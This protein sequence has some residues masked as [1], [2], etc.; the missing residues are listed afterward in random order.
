[1]QIEFEGQLYEFPDDA[2]DVEIAEALESVTPQQP[3]PS[4]GMADRAGAPTSDLAPGFSVVHTPATNAPLIVTM[5][6]GTD[7]SFPADMPHDEIRR[8]IAGKFPN[9][10]P[11]G[12]KIVSQPDSPPSTAYDVAAAIPSGLAR[13]AVETVMAPVTAGRLA[14]DGMGW[15]YDKGEAG[16]RALIGA[17]PAAANSEIEAWRDYNPIRDLIFGAQDSV[18]GVMDD[19]L[20]EAKTLAGKFAQTGAEFAAPGALPGKAARLAPT[21]AGKAGNYARDFFGNVAAPAVLSEGAGQLTEG[22]SWEG[23]ARALAAVSGNAAVAA[24]R[25]FNAPDSVVRRAT[26]D[27]SDTDWQRAIGLQDNTTGIRLTGPEAIA[28][29][30]GG[31]SALPDVQRVIEGSVGGRAIT[32]PFFAQRPIQV[33]SAVAEVLDLIAPQAANPFT[34]GSRAAAAADNAITDVRGRINDSTRPLYQAAEPQRLPSPE[35]STVSSNP[36]FAAAVQRLRADRELGPRYAS[37]PDDSVGVIDAVAKDLFERGEA[38]GNKANPTYG[39]YKGSLSTGAAADARNAASRS[40]PE[41]AQ[42]LAEQER[43]RE[44]ILGPLEAGPVGQVA[45]TSDTASA[46]N[47]ILPQNPMTGSGR[48]TAL[49]VRMLDDQDPSATRGLIRQNLTDR[50]QRAATETQEGSREFAGAKFR[51]DVAGNDARQEVLDAVFG[52]LPNGPTREAADLLDVLQATGRRKPIGSA[53]AF[54]NSLQEELSGA[55]SLPGL[56]KSVGLSLGTYV[57]KAGDAVQRATMGRNIDTLADMFVDPRSVERIR[58]A[59]TRRPTAAFDDAARRS[60][61]QLGVS[62]P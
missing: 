55:Q 48:E 59:T 60:A 35:F 20:Y 2:T 53:T 22:T 40:S 36:S 45:K 4:Y 17:E 42:A 10:I 25:S 39:P 41:Y 34:L 61:L 62:A 37:M 14:E 43:L 29:V 28:Q 1:M 44:L 31:A 7:V 54:N 3:K 32:A 49:A 18:R 19:N 52:A 26:G 21:L 12:F 23:P 8:L 56:A 30:T 50:Y 13:G 38:M 16:V 11:P 5:P 15:L 9:D 27:M 51:K 57:T 24:N 58:D 46:G 47:A 33:D 6:D